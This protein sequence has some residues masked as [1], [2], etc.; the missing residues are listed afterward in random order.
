MSGNGLYPGLNLGA[1]HGEAHED[2]EKTVFG[3]WVFLMSDLIIFGI[4]FASYASYLD[5]IGMAGGPGPK[6]LFDLTSVAIQTAFL[7]VSGI[8]YAGVSLGLKYDQGRAKIIAWLLVCALLGAGFLFFEV[9]DFIAQAGEGGVP[10]A[11]GWL[12]SYWALVGLHGIHV[13]SGIL[14]IFATIGQI[15]TRGLDDVVKVRL[16]MLGVFWHFLDL[17]WVGIFSLVFLVPLA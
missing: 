7:L 3:F 9:K 10:Q 1:T 17:I 11:S 14:W 16:S 2:A 6:D 12:S 8:A 4:L 15:A 5:P 13:F